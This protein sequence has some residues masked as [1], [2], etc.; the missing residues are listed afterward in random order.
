MEYQVITLHKEIFGEKLNTFLYDQNGMLTIQGD[1]RVIG[2]ALYVFTE[3]IMD[4]HYTAVAPEYRGEGF[5]HEVMKGILAHACRRMVSLITLE[6][7]SDNEVA[8]HLYKKTGF[9]EVNVRKKYYKD[10]C[11]ALLLNREISINDLKAY[12]EDDEYLEV[13]PPLED[14]IEQVQ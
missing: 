10:G 8:I 1:D 2:Y 13:Y 11:D 4:V 5:G 7:R 14:V 9:K 3:N 12:F 6:V